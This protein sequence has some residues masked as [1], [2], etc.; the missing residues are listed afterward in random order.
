MQYSKCVKLPWALLLNV[1]D[2]GVARVLVKVI[3]VGIRRIR[4][5]CR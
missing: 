4:G 5:S 2:L 1:S 3:V